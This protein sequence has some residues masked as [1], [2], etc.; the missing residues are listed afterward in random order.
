MLLVSLLIMLQVIGDTSY[1]LRL[2]MITGRSRDEFR[3]HILIFV[4]KIHPHL[5]LQT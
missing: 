3:Y 4:K 2:G 5:H 1:N